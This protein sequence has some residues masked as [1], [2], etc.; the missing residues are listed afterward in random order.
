MKK[1][2]DS[3]KSIV[4]SLLFIL[5][6]VAIGFVIGRYTSFLQ[7][8]QEEIVSDND[9]NGLTLPFETKRETVTVL[10]VKSTLEELS[11]FSTYECVYTVKKGKDLSRFIGKELKIPGTTNNV[12]LTCDGVVKVGYDI[13]D[14]GV[15]V[16]NNTIFI[17]LPEKATI[18]DN[19]II[20]DTVEV[21]EK[22]NILNPI[23]FSQYKALISEIEE[24]GLEQA[25]SKGIYDKAEKN[26]KKVIEGF[27]SK[28]DDYEIEYN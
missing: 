7:Q 1:A 27:L 15:E 6:F 3:F 20:W 28:F 18:N 4:S 9:E 26:F 13:N 19:Y 23:E 21:S 24:T 22:N 17:T 8:P 2:I 14:I 16:N 12:T 11:D 5:F 10:D 25:E